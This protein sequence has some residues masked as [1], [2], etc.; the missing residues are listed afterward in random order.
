M[1]TKNIR[2]YM[3]ACV[4]QKVCENVNFF[5]LHENVQPLKM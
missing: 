2:G 4:R 1:L 5:A 3:I